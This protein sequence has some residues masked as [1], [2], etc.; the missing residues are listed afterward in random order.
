MLHDPFALVAL[1]GAALATPILL[2]FLIRRPALGRSTK[3]WLLFGIGLFPLLTAGSGNIAGFEATKARRFCGSCHVMTPYASDSEDPHSTSLAAIHA[4]NQQ[5]GGDNCYTCHADYGMF[6]TI[7]T[8]LGGLRHVYEY[9][10]HFH[11]LT[12]AE[13]LPRIHIRKPFR[14]ATC[15]RCH[16]THAPSWS[17]VGDHVG[18]LDELR[19]GAV[20]CVGSGCHG[21]AHPFSKVG[22]GEASP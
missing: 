18:L 21:P 1:G 19:S 11:Q 3:I 14:N 17:Q 4:R 5:F 20:S 2:W 6:G 12:L 7:V 9:T 16:T 13:A 22:R 8:K 15:L 10:F